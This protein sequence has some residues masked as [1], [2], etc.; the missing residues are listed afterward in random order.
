MSVR[1]LDYF[2]KPATVAVIGAT[3]R[4]HSIGATLTRNLLDGGYRGKILPV[5]AKRA[6]VFGVPAYASVEA[7]PIAPELAVICTP[8]PSVPGL[9]AALGAR[10][11]K[12]AIVITAGLQRVEV[13]PGITA[14]D[15]VLAAARP[16]LLRVIGPN[17][18]GMLVPGIGLNASFAPGNARPGRIAFVTQSGALAAA[19]LDW[20]NAQHLGFSCFISIGD[21]L[22]VDLG[23]L[24]DYLGRDADTS[25]ILLYIES[26]KHPRKFMSAARAAARAKPVIA[27][28]AGRAAAGARAAASH[29]GA[30]AGDDAVVDAVLTRAGILRV[31]TTQ[32][33]FDAAETLA[34]GKPYLGPRVALLT[35]GG[36]AGVLAADALSSQ[37][38]Q[39]AELSQASLAALD[40]V[41]PP[42]WSRANPL[43]IIGDAPVARYVDALNIVTAAAE[44]DAVLLLHAPTAIV[45]SHEIAEAVVPI[46]KASGKNILTCFMGGDAVASARALLTTHD[47]PHY[48]TPEDTV[49]AYRQL[50]RRAAL[51]AAL[52]ETPARELPEDEVA[53]CRIRELLQRV[54][55]E[56]RELLTEVEAKAVLRDAGI[57]VVATEI[58]RSPAEAA[59][60]AVGIGFPVALKIL[61]PDI[62]HKSDIDGVRLHL[63]DTQDVREAAAQMLQTVARLRPNAVITGFT[64]QRMVSLANAHELILGCARDPVFGPVLMFGHGGVAV[65]VLKDRS[66]G[67]PP[68]SLPLAHAMVENTRIYALLRGYRDRPPVAFDAVYDALLRL[69]ALTV[70]C[71]EIVELDINP[72]LANDTGVQALDAR[73]EL[74]PYDGDPTA[75]LIVCPY[76]RRLEEEIMF[77]GEPLCLRPIKPTDEGAHEKFLAQVSEEDRYFRFFQ[78]RRTWTHAQLAQLTQIDYDREMAF[79]A[80]NAALTPEI[81]GVARLITD[82]DRETAEFA[83]VVRSD[84]QGE[85][86]GYRLL[87]KLIRYARA[88]GIGELVGFVLAEN[89]GM[90]GLAVELGFNVETRDSAG[91]I[92]IALKLG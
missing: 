21:S 63:S 69:S 15:A 22:D 91:V 19:V 5:N 50:D 20:G 38:G 89:S 49:H 66:F 80:V 3:E 12:A 31:D 11:T 79:V 92:K 76:P 56:G 27:V 1:N 34:R 16:H 48:S 45:P 85:G 29:T 82:P 88:S 64:V 39:L 7:L 55:A 17:C 75:R 25:A 47:I 36:G 46:I 86:L 4:P 84:R 44:V 78:V 73:I 40:A 53:L 58:A 33:L 62:T 18:L 70:A 65:E 72:L 83:I 51:H 28:K 42:T 32:D 30:L 37:G 52:L 41:L 9:I 77:R 60:L 24:L 2:F 61:S 87:D 67:L 43:D 8:A 71:P 6:E 10:G 57:P 59:T 54:L 74:A 68:L 35:N 26:I 90:L 13:S 23:D 14:G 81:L